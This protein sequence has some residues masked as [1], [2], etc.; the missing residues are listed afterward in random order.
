MLGLCRSW[1]RVGSTGLLGRMFLC[2]GSGG[3]SIRRGGLVNFGNHLADLGR[4]ASR[5]FRVQNA[6]DGRRQID[7]SLVRFQLADRLINCH[8][9]TLIFEPLQEDCFGDRFAQRRNFDVAGHDGSLA[10][11]SG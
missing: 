8:L 4:F 7:S 3:R 1:L 9:V 10:Y 5:F 6:T 11:A 2:R